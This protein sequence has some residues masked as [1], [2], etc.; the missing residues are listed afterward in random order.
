MNFEKWMVI[1]ACIVVAYGYV[2]LLDFRQ[3]KK[4][5]LRK[6]GAIT[7][8]LGIGIVST[9]LGGLQSI[10]GGPMIGLFIGM[11][12]VNVLPGLDEEFKGGTTFS[13]KKYLNLGIVLVGATLNYTAILSATRAL[14]LLLI[15][16]GISFGVAFLA[17]RKLLRLNSNICTLVG[18][19]T[20]I[21]G[22]SAIAT[23]SSIIKAKEEEIAYAM[24]AIFLFDVLAALLYPYLA[25]WVGLNAQ[26]FGYLV[27]AAVND[28]SS[29]VASQATYMARHPELGEFSLGITVKL[30][31]TTLILL[32]AVIFT[33]SAI[34]KAASEEVGEKTSIGGTILSVF[35]WFILAFLI[36]ALINT[37]GIFDKIPGAAAFFKH[38][39]KFFVSV[40]LGGVGF[41]IKFKDLF[42][43]GMKPIALGG[44]TWIA[45]FLSSL[46][47]V[48]LF[49]G[50]IS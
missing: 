37:L 16:I 7:L 10:I 2:W 19:G 43:K 40:A 3:K 29:V 21:C 28:T 44:C 13:A 20:S 15:N 9:W 38:G 35:P 48:V 27:G 31:R 14:P 12:L 22:G 8:C 50:F 41:K 46:L 17:G 25:E 6:Y 49:K 36:M 11:L 5:S 39:N 45:V 33:V 23:L 24:T 34:R 18:G 4:F 26:Q 47:F 42:S 32:L 30:V 1:L